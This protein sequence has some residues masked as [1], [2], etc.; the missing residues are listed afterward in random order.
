[1]HDPD[2]IIRTSGEQRTSNYLLWQGA[3]SELVFADELWPDFSREAVQGR[4]GRVR[5][6][7]A[8][9]RGALMEGR[10][11]SASRRRAT[12]SQRRAGRAR[13]R[14]AGSDLGARLAAAIPAIA[15]AL[16]IVGFGNW[17][18][19]AG[20]AALSCICLHELFGMYAFTNPSR[21][22]GFTG[23]IALLVAAHLGGQASVLGAFVACV[24]VGLRAVPAA[25][26]P[27]RGA[28]RGG[29]DA[30]PELDRPGLR[31]R[32]DAARPAPR[33]RDR[34]RRPG[35]DVHR[36]HRGLPRRAHLRHAA[37]SRRRS[38]PT[39]RS[40]AWPSAS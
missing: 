19:V 39:R 4:A 26:A 28:R 40:R 13:R 31:A 21:L 27:R 33:R 18:F 30:R 25:A 2:L 36:R 38:R 7:A 23:R 17:V 9:V 20:L 14:N 34:H 11:R 8:P 32:R 6:P 5:A 35:R 24:P 1:M 22:A 37:A 3:Y 12:A 29:D 16:A 10:S 15:F